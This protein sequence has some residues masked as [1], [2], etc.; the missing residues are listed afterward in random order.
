MEIVESFAKSIK[1]M[2][3]NNTP[4]KGVCFFAESYMKFA[5]SQH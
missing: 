2:E 3:Q 4:E 5:T 1:S